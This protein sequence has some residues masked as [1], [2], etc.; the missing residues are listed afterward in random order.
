MDETGRGRE[1]RDEGGGEETGA[2]ERN[3]RRG[4]DTERRRDSRFTVCVSTGRV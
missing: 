3:V 4:K 2:D 1:Q